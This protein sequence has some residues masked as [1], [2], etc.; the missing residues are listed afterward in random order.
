MSLH[1]AARPGPHASPQCHRVL[2]PRG[3]CANLACS[4]CAATFGPS[5]LDRCMDLDAAD[6]QPAPSDLVTAPCSSALRLN[7]AVKLFSLS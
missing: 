2:Q 5:H 6:Y 7:F 3:A 4:Y 1:C